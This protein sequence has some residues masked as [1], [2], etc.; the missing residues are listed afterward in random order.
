MLK[1]KDYSESA[2]MFTSC[3]KRCHGEDMGEL[4]NLN[5]YRKKRERLQRK[6]SAAANRMRFGRPK[7]ETIQSKKERVRDDTELDG[8]QLSD[9]PNTRTDPDDTPETG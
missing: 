1:L 9:Q 7:D 4:V 2:G 8:K 3:E 5:Q 6:K